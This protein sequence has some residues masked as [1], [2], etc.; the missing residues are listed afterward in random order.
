MASYI[1]L[2]ELDIAPLLKA[3]KMFA[4]A[5][6]EAKSPLEKTGAI[7][8]FEFC[9]ELAWKTMRRILIKKGL[10]ANN[11]RDV[12]RLAAAN[13]LIEDPEAWF[14]SIRKRNLTVHTYDEELAEDIFV[15]LPEFKKYL[16]SFVATV[17][18]MS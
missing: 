18:H 11:P 10:E 6:I 13:G 12:F 9:Y 5:L 3:Q 8:R 7:Q 15:W 14:E 17:K 1:I 4:D 16:D 2:G